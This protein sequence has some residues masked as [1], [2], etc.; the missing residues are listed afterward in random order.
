MDLRER[1]IELQLE[2]LRTLQQAIPDA[3]GA[4]YV[5]VIAG[6]LWLAA[7]NYTVWR[8]IARQRGDIPG[9]EASDGPMF[10]SF[11]ANVWAEFSGDQARTTL[12]AAAARGG[13]DH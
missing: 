6:I 3:N 2:T 5:G 11:A 10:L 9:D 4:E 12:L 13:G 8:E 1:I 7:F